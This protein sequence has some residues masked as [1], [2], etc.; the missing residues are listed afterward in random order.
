M[1]LPSADGTISKATDRE[2]HSEINR[3]I[4]REID[5]EIDRHNIDPRK[6]A[7]AASASALTGK[8]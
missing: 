7:A 6:Y 1:W 2:I 3:E 8:R 5:S 4:D